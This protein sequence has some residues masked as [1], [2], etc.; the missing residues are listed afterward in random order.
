MGKKPYCFRGQTGVL[1]ETKS[2]FTGEGAGLAVR[3]HLSGARKVN[4]PPSVM[5]CSPGIPGW[6]IVNSGY[7]GNGALISEGYFRPCG[8]CSGY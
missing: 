8:I 4:A 5:M 3:E 6:L 1:S 2:W 7:R